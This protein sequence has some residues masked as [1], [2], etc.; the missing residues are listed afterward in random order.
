M[1]ILTCKGGNWNDA[2]N[3]EPN[4]VPTGEDM[5]IL[6]NL[7]GDIYCDITST[8]KKLK[9]TDFKGNIEYGI[10]GG[11]IRQMGMIRNENK[12]DLFLARPDIERVD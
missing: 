10:I 9:M 3:F 12:Y 1:D 6:D 7:T 11:S 5:V 2:Q 4:K 8:C